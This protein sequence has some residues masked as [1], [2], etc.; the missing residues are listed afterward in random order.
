[1]TD[2]TWILALGFCVVSIIALFASGFPMSGKL[3]DAE[4]DIIDGPNWRKHPN[5]TRYTGPH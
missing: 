2:I 3:T 4:R 5:R 1:M